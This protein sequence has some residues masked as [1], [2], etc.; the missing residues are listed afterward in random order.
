[1]KAI[2]LV[3]TKKTGKT[4]LGLSLV[5]ELLDRGV[6]VA[7]AKHTRHHFDRP[8]T[9]TA[10]YAELG[11]QVIGVCPQE[12]FVRWPSERFLPDLLP[13]VEADLVVVE[14]GKDLGWLP[15]VILAQDAGKAAGLSPELALAA[16]TG[17]E[18]LVPVAG[19][20]EVGSVALLAD[21][22]LSRGF[23]LPGLDC[24][25]CGREDC[26]GLAADIVAGRAAPGDC[27]ATGQEIRVTVNGREL[28]LNPF[29]AKFLEAGITA[30][31]ATL[32]G[33]V[34]GDLRIE[35]TRSR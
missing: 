23:A 12:S 19:T 22:A 8:D 35:I 17:S 7:V 10:R 29:V 30:Q 6:R 20:P 34:P 13:L 2:A 26:R 27:Q 33:Y 31:L 9:D 25:A 28:A 1:M 4:A 16:W 5:R 11:A 3:G 15:R 21:L 14:G 18:D 24:G 32:K